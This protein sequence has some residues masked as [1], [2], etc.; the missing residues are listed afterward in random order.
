MSQGAKPYSVLYPPCSVRWAARR[1]R[2]RPSRTSLLT[3]AD[4]GAVRGRGG[5]VAR[6]TLSVGLSLDQVW[7]VS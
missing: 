4:A 2:G 3:P 1:P 7:T 5:R 6:P